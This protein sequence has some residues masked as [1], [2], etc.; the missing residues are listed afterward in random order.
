M[1]FLFNPKRVSFVDRPGGDAG[2]PVSVV[3]TGHR[4]ALSISPGRIDPAN[5]AW[6]DSR[7]PL[8]GEFVFRGRT[9]FVVANHFASKGGDQPMHGRYQPPTRGSEVQ[10]Q[11]QATVLRGFVDQLREV[12]PGA[13]VVLAGDLNDYQ[14][15]QAL[16]TL[17]R[18][19]VVRDLIDTLPAAERYS[20]VYEGNSQVL[21]HILVG[22]RRGATDYDVVHVNAEFADQASDHDPQVLRMRLTPQT[23]LPWLDDFCDQ[24]DDLLDRLGRFR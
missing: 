16:H 14:F 22:G 20:Y 2:T 17:T 23:G 21:D 19:G 24:L 1:A 5:A 6:Q 11:Q 15:S 3:R 8:A 18:G 13:T 9:V 4:A 7:K 10:R 12:D